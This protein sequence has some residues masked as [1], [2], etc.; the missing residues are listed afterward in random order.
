MGKLIFCSVTKYDFS[1]YVRL[2]VC[3]DII[4][5]CHNILLHFNHSTNITKII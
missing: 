3:N 1:T 4:R 2:Y 5:M